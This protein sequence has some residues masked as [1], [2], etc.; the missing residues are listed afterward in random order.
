MKIFGPKK[1]KTSQQDIADMKQITQNLELV[2]AEMPKEILDA[3]THCAN[4]KDEI[5]QSKKCGCFYCFNIYSATEV[6]EWIESGK[7]ATCPMCGI[8]S[9]I[10]DASGSELT[11]DFLQSMHKYWF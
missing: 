9:V 7:T 5:N 8:D 1:H 3:H 10:G 4:N 11:K 2:K 6:K